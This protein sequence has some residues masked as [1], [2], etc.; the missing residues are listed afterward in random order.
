[1]HAIIAAACRKETHAGRLVLGTSNDTPNWK[2]L[3][4]LKCLA[5]QAELNCEYCRSCREHD[6]CE[7][8]YLHKFR[9]TYTTNLLR[10][11]IDVRT[12]MMY[13]GHSEMATV[14]RYLSAAGGYDTQNKINSI[15]WT[16]RTYFTELSVLKEFSKSF[17][18]VK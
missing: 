18:D 9:V 7:R 16:R 10:A 5:P 11:G 6:E 2:W 12:V 14:L 4:I 1:M 13:A 8:W 15:Q 3:P 17:H